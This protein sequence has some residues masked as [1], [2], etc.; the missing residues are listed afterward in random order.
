M[1]RRGLGQSGGRADTVGS[2]QKQSPWSHVV[3]L[4]L[5]VV[6]SVGSSVTWLSGCA[7]SAAKPAESSESVGPPTPEASKTLP[8]KPLDIDDPAREPDSV[9]WTTPPAI[10]DRML[11]V[12]EV[13]STDVVY[14]LGSGDG[15]LVIAAAQRFG[16]HGVGYEIDQKLVDLATKL[17]SE[18]GVSHLVRFERKDIFTV[19]LSQASVITMYLLPTVIEQLIPQLNKLKPGSRIVSHNYPMPGVEPDR[20]VTAH[21]PDSEHFLLLWHP[22]LKITKPAK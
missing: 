19:D 9:Y 16:A 17:A 21:L 7:A 20:V 8:R 10:V 2:R 14:D 5:V 11:E 4:L 3:S 18:A 6:A 13:K 1:K 12:A 22:P 15:R